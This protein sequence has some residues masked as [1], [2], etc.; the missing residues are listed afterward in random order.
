MIV[1]F[2]RGE[3][4]FLE[5]GYSSEVWLYEGGLV[6]KGS[7][8]CLW[9][10]LWKYIKKG[11]DTFLCFI[12]FEVGDGSNIKFW[13]DVWCGDST[14]KVCFPELYRISWN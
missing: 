2:W 6:H 9:V 1:A 12:K 8:W 10:S 14:L 4:S 3:G 11:W 7:P 13:M 5:K